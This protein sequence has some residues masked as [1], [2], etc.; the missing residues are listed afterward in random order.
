MTILATNMSYRLVSIKHHSYPSGTKLK[1]MKLGLFSLLFVTEGGG[2]LKLN[3]DWQDL[4]SGSCFV[5][6]PP[7]SIELGAP[8]DKGSLQ[9]YL[10]QFV[11]I[12][13]CHEES[14]ADEL[15]HLDTPPIAMEPLKAVLPAFAAIE[16]LLAQLEQS[17]H[18]PRTWFRTQSLFHELLHTLIEQVHEQAVSP[19]IRRTILYME[20]H[21]TESLQ[22]G[23][24]PA[25]AG[26]T[27]NSYCRAFKKVTG[28][29]PSRY[30][31]RLRLNLAKQL[32]QLSSHSLKDVAR[33]VG[34][35]DELYFSRVFKQHE[36]VAPTL[37]VKELP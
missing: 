31:T 17:I 21:F 20:R 33:S 27:P 37:Y 12:P 28:L 16:A 15:A 4:E 22:V 23:D 19:S 25:M 1:P 5:W 6:Q 11:R 36:G 29:T 35:Q 9:C 7:S 26:L 32:L 14:Y 10:L 13:Y 18:D 3:E 24:L 2:R 8:E 34:Y 30:L